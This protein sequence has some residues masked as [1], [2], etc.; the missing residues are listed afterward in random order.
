[1]DYDL[2]SDLDI[3]ATSFDTPNNLFRND[4]G[5]Q[6]VDVAEEAGLLRSDVENRTAAW[7]DFDGDGLMDV[8]I[9]R[10]SAL[11]KN[12]GDG[13][14][15]DVTAAAGITA[16]A[17]AQGG[18]WGD[19]DNDGDLD[20]YVTMG[21]QNG[22]PLQGIL[23]RNNGDGTFTDVTTASGAINIAGALGVTW[24]DYDNDGYLDLYIVNTEDGT[25]TPN[26]LFRNNG[27]G[28]FTD[29]ATT[30]GVGA[31]PGAGR[32][33][34]ATFADYNNDGFLDLFV[35]NGGGSSVGPYLLYR[36]NGNSNGWLN[37][38]LIGQQSNRSGIGAKISLRAG[39]RQQF[40]EYT[41][42]HYMSQN[43]IPV[44]FGLG[45]QPIVDSLSILWPSGIRQTLHHVAVNQTIT[46]TESAE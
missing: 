10:S 18:A 27:D 45:R 44:H 4:G 42:Q 7:A 17:D 5:F 25:S 11:F 2:D 28:T 30:A 19:Y 24:G 38:V 36:N 23:Y 26:R 35:C 3:F 6:F 29:V 13:T 21:E 31:K 15:V 37:V 41:G 33:S 43:H 14:F 9:T 32:G 8:F 12:L 16:S 22:P 1:V 46:V 20:L 39:R 34:D 40:T